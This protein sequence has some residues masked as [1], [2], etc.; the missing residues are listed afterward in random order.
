MKKKRLFFIIYSHRTYT[1]YLTATRTVLCCIT[2]KDETYQKL[3]EPP[4][5]C[6]IRTFMVLKFDH[7]D[8]LNQQHIHSTKDA[9]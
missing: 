8:I 1:I 2:D 4:M 3:P 9:F 5:I 6:R 7:W